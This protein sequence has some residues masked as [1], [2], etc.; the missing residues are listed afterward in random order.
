MESTSL[1]IEKLRDNENWLQWHFVIRTL[2][3]EDDDTLSVCEGKLV[4]PAE[5]SANYQVNLQ[6]FLKTD[7]TARRLIVTSVEKKPLDL[8][9]S[10]TSAREMW[11]KLNAVYDM[12]SDENLSIVQKQFFDFKWDSSESVS[13]NLAKVEQLSTKMKN[14]G[15]AVPDSMILTRI[16][17]ILPKIFNHFHSAWDSVED[18]K[19][20]LENL[21]ARLMTEEVR[22]QEQDGSEDMSV[23]LLMKRRS[24]NTL[25]PKNNCHHKSNQ[26]ERWKNS[27]SGCYTCGKT[28]HIRKDCVGCNRC[29]SKGHLSRNCFKRNGNFRTRNSGGAHTVQQTS[30]STHKQAFVGSS[31]DFKGDDV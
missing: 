9:L 1:K 21:T 17:S 16:L 26:D 22:T 30:T 10:C 19:K 15:G 5:N 7:K 13:H 6:R 14:L 18:K 3:E 12:K 2:L 4:R 11:K 25:F 8:L 31:S 29:G 24:S 27:F 28:D 23:A 20:T